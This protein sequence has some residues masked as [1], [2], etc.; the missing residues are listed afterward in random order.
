MVR[1]DGRRL[2]TAADAPASQA[3]CCSSASTWRRRD[4]ADALDALLA[5]L[6]ELGEDSLVVDVPADD[7]VLAAALAGRPLQLQATQMLLDLADVPAPPARVALRPMTAAEFAGLPRPAHHGVR[8]GHARRRRLHRPRPRARG[9]RGL[10]RAAAARRT[11]HTGP[12]PL[13]G[14]RRRGAGRRSSGSPSTGPRV[15]S[16]T[17]RSTTSSAAAATAGRSWT[18]EHE[19]PSTSAPGSSASTCSGT[20]TAPARS[21]SARVTPRPSGPTGSRL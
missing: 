1:R 21:T 13:D 5:A 20:T 3:G 6:R 18:P 15:T 14:V 11:G 17:S 8:P 16:T 12:P 9:I 7:P 19:P 10:H 2:G 4:A